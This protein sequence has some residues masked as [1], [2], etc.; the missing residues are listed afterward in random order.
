MSLVLILKLIV[1]PSVVLGQSFKLLPSVL[2]STTHRHA[3]IKS[4]HLFLYGTTN[5]KES[6]F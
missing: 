5:Y 1:T 2:L 6:K 3:W 4:R